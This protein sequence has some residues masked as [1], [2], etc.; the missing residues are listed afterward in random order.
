[1]NPFRP[2]LTYA[3]VVATLALFLA[4]GGGAYAATQLPNN[5]VGTNQLKKNAVISQKV[6]DG[7]LL[8]TDFKSGQ[9]PRGP[10]GPTFGSSNGGADVAVPSKPYDDPPPL[11]GGG[12]NDTLTT[13]A[14][15]RL[16]VVAAVKAVKVYCTPVTNGV[17]F[18]TLDGTA[19]PG[20]Q[21]SNAGMDAPYVTS[22]VTAPLP[23]GTHTLSL[24]FDCGSATPSG[25]SYANDGDM[26][27]VL[28]GQ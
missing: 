9:L 5:S 17:V 22:V 8:A 18:V 6:K 14:R 19:I 2:H 13:P 23:A 28:L 27:T 11:P 25:G 4:L 7:S 10:V 16:L 12:V 21:Q 26:T 1:M 15:G 24:A 20:T 3:N